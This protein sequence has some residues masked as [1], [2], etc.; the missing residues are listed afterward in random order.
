[1]SDQKRPYRMQRRAELEERYRRACRRT[2]LD[3]V[4]PLPGR[5]RAVRGLLVAL[6]RGEPAARRARL[7]LDR[8]AGGAHRDRASRAVLVLPTHPG[9][10]RKPA[11]RR[12][13]RPERPPPPARLL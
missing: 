7:G 2:P 8:G 11:P 3:G 5:G 9:D 13:A 6:A 10:V 1:M 12:A 4:S